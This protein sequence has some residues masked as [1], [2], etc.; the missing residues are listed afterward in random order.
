MNQTC[1]KSISESGFQF[2]V[3]DHAG[4]VLLD[5]YTEWCPPCKMMAPVL[6]AVCSDRAGALKVLKINA[7]ESPE[8]ATRLNVLSVPTFILYRNGEQ[9]ARMSGYYAKPAFDQWI[10]Q[11][12][13]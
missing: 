12:L 9:V 7:E 8:L 2:E 11:T 1:T 13:A 10:N 3:A 6:E 4:D 5:F